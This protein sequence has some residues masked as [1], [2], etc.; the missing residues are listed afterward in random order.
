[1]K[2]ILI[3]TTYAFITFSSCKKDAA[4]LEGAKQDNMKQDNMVANSQN[5]AIVTDVHFD[6]P[7]PYDLVNQCT[8]ETLT[9]TGTIGDDIHIV[10]NGN[11]MN[12]S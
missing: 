2:K 4:Y 1:M 9:V 10:I 8:G 6:L 11:T 12:F 3:I 7:G 5:S